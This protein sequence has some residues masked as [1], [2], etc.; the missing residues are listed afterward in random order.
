MCECVRRQRLCT[1]HYDLAEPPP[2]FLAHTK[3][4]AICRH[5]STTMVVGGGWYMLNY[6]HV[7]GTSTHA[8]L[9]MG[10]TTYWEYH[11]D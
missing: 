6:K 4:A 5:W 9:M 3:A 11:I 10:L 1:N 8:K 2:V 7:L